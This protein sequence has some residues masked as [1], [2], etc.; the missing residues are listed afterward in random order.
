MQVKVGC[1]PPSE[2]GHS[3]GSPIG[4]QLALQPARAGEQL[5]QV[6]QPPGSNQ[7]VAHILQ[8]HR[9]RSACA[10]FLYVSMPAPSFTALHHAS[11]QG[12]GRSDA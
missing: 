3:A 1:A 12:P 11:V 5:L 10:A 9:E 7:V 4:V 8:E 6:F 2:V